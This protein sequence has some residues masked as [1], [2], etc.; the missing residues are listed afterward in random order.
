MKKE[1]EKLAKELQDAV[2]NLSGMAYFEE[3]GL[4]VFDPKKMSVEVNYLLWHSFS[5][6]GLVKFCHSL[7]FNMQVKVAATKEV[8]I[9]A[10]PII[11]SVNYGIIP[12]EYGKMG[13]V[14][15]C[16]YNS[17]TGFSEV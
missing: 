5:T 7:Y 4:V 16:H 15:M 13:V 11:I 3:K 10:E 1:D 17:V 6:K 8:V 14:E 2:K 9:E 12:N